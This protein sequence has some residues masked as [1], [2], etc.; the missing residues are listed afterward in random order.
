MRY[1]Q[2]G[3]LSDERRQ[4]REGIRPRAA[5]RFAQVE[6]GPLRLA[7]GG[8]GQGTG[9]ARLAG[10][11]VDAVE[12][13]DRDRTALP[14]ELHPARGA[15]AADPARFLLPDPGEESRRTRRG[16]DL[17]LGEGDLA[18]GGRTAAAL[19]AWVVFEDES[20]FSMTPPT[21]RTWAR[22]GRTPVIRVRGRSR[23]RISIAALT[24]C[25]PGERSRLI[26]RPRRDDGRRG[27]LSNTAFTTPE[28]LIQTIRHGMR[29]TQYR[30]TSS[31]DASPEPA[32]PSRR[33]HQ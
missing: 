11:A 20:G 33:R 1:A 3:G 27:W 2:G 25:K 8:V 21:A 12:G 18:A 5:E 17:R 4:F 15:Q 9:R 14:Q 16:G 19:D 7:G 13:Q 24:C 31:T 28:H 6:R 32:W 23:R 10:P 30:P 29:K 26:Y 22:R